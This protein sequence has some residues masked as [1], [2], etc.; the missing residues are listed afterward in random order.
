[1]PPS[2]NRAACHSPEYRRQHGEIVRSGRAAFVPFP[3]V[4]E[5]GPGVVEPP[6][7]AQ[8]ASS[9]TTVDT[10]TE[11]PLRARV[12]RAAASSPRAIRVSARSM[13]ACATRLVWS[14]SNCV[15]VVQPSR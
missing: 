3:Q 4:D 11:E 15:A 13:W 7:A 2:A 8:Q 12:A 9:S 1:M 6:R 10:R 14:T 5:R